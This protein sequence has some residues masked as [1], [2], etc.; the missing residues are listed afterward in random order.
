MSR[1]RIA[2]LEVFYHVGVTQ[3]ERAMPQRLLLTIGMSG[4]FSLAEMSDDLTKT[5]DYAMVA[6]GA[7]LGMGAG[8]LVRDKSISRALICTVAALALGLFA[9]WRFRP[10]VADPRLG[11]FLA[12]IHQLQPITMLMIAAG[13]GLGGWLALGQER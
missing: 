9:E 1:I 13:A 3:E 2:D 5:I 7:L 11:Y 12:H 6:P 4:D 8:L 10:F